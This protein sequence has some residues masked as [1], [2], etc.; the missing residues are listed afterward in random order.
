[1]A[2]E[3]VLQTVIPVFLTILVGFLISKKKKLDIQPIV[4]LVVYIASP[5]LIFASMVSSKLPISN[6][7][8]VFIAACL[9]IIIQGAITLLI[10]RRTTKENELSLPVVIGNSGF[11]GY[12]VALFA[13]GTLGLSNAIA[14]DMANSLFIFSIGIYLVHHKNDIK[15]M[16]KLPLIYAVILGI[17]FNLFKI[18][19]PEIIFKPIEMIG[20]IAIPLALL[21]L[22]YNLNQIKL[23]QINKAFLLS[24]SRILGGLLIAILI[25]AILRIEGVQK[26]I[27]LLQSAMPSAVMSMILASKY[28]RNPELISSVVLITTLISIV[29]IPLILMFL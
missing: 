11:L 6:F 4:D 1:M 24:L 9:I 7:L 23:T 14:Y 5:C 20:T 17:I 3:I 16:F 2:L 12:P 27:I 10:I 26:N 18:N 22:G 13:F 21:V 25:V 15:E 28:H 8:Q 29:T 19:V